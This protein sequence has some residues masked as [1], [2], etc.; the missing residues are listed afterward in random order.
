MARMQPIDV[1]IE[2]LAYAAGLLGPDEAA[3]PPTEAQI[4]DAELALRR[5]LP[6]S[7]VAFMNRAGHIL[8]PDWD[9]Y[10][11]GGPEMT[12]RRNIVIANEIERD[13]DTSPLPPFLIAF[14]D[15]GNGDQHCFDTRDRTVAGSTQSV[16][17]EDLD[18]IG[19]YR[20]PGEHTHDYPVV[21]WDRERGL[22]QVREG[23]YVVATDF[24][25]WLKAQVHASV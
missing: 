19:D 3:P 15:D 9:V 22:D 8:M 14:C 4:A 1:A 13:H 24:I 6:P 12:Q 5:K 20:R 2:S 16:E 21:L 25:D 18:G 7:Y 17:L 23:L 10:W 11:V